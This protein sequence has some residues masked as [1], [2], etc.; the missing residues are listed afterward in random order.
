MENSNNQ[1]ENFTISCAEQSE[2][3]VKGFLTTA[4]EQLFYNNSN[5]KNHIIAYALHFI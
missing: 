2:N 4:D 5:G 3:S 1:F